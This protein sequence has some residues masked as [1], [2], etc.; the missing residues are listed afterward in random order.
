MDKHVK[1]LIEQFSGSS[2]YIKQSGIKNRY[3]YP[4]IPTIV[5]DN[6]YEEPDLW[7]EYA[8]SQEFYKGDRGSWPG[9]RTKLL[10]ELDQDIFRVTLRKLLMVMS[11]YG[12]S[13]FL[14]LQTGFQMID[15]TYGR[16]W[17]HDDDPKL[18]IAGVIYLNKEA[19]LDSG[20]TIYKDQNDFN[21]DKYTEMF[22]DDVLIASPE[23]RAK[24]EKYR[25]EQVAHFQKT[26]TVESVYNRL[27]I[28]DTRNWHSAEKF[29]GNSV[30]SSRL[31]QVVFG[32]IR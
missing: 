22:M 17:V 6:F 28:F 8:L 1:Q 26:I 14:E 7:R 23:D 27:I 10:H 21:G 31:T 18:N 12:Y 32:K 29:F 16:G 24:Y 13:E 2:E 15:S 4:Y 9:L 3:L 19:P 25:E 11:Q 20:T 30:E 5:I